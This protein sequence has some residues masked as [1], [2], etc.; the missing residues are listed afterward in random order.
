MADEPHAVELNFCMTAMLDSSVEFSWNNWICKADSEYYEAWSK[1][2]IN[3]GI[4]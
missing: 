2:W 3:E 1:D 4:F